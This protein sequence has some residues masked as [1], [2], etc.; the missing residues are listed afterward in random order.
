MNQQKIYPYTTCIYHK[1]R[2]RSYNIKI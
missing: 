2:N 1:K